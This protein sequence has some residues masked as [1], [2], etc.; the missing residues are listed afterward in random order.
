M[1]SHITINKTLWNHVKRQV[2]VLSDIF[3]DDSNDVYHKDFTKLQYYIAA[4]DA[5]DAKLP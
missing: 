1:A 2:D 4:I 5:E 3:D